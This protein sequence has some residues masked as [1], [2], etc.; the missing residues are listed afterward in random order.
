MIA[1][2]TPP[3]AI[4]TASL[5]SAPSTWDA[6]LTLLLRRYP[7]AEWG[8]F[9]RFGWRDTPDGLVLTLAALDQPT[10]GDLDPR[11]DIVAFQEPYTLR[12]VLDTEAGPLAFGVIHSHPE[13][14]RTWPSALD[15]DMDTY[16]SGYVAGFTPE[17]PYVSLIVARDED[18]SVRA[19]GRVFWRGQWRP[20][21]AF[22]VL[23]HHVAL[24]PPPVDHLIGPALDQ[25]FGGATAAADADLDLRRVAR[26]ASAFGAEA[27]ARL[28]RA[29]VAVIGA[30]GTGSPILEVLARAGVGRIITVDPDAFSASNLERVHGSLLTDVP[31]EGKEGAPKVVLAQRH[32]HAI[33]PHC[34][35]IA[36][37]G[38]LPQ[39]AVLDA[40]LH[41]DVAIGCTDQIHSR[42]ALSELAAR[43]LVPVLDVGV[44]LEGE[45]GLCSGLVVGLTRFLPEDPCA[46]CRGMVD[47]ARLTREL[48]SPGER[49]ARRAAAA[50]AVARGEDGGAYWHDDPQLNTVGFLT[51]TAGGMAAGYAIGWVTG[52]FVLPFSRTEMNLALP[53]FGVA[54]Q[55]ETEG[56]PE[57]TCTCRLMLGHADQGA[58]HTFL[59]APAHWVPVVR[60]RDLK[61]LPR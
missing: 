28:A 46:Y 40:V 51:T 25:V 59:T 31:P 41:A 14:Y 19:S 60:H 36:L 42:V 48:M 44:V 54:D 15:D 32:I 55:T 45:E 3:R 10:P 35:V 12:S 24:D 23:P 8:T 38:A 27:A 47:T 50:E 20:I 4:L 2:R 13:G 5:R 34:E 43:F 57:P 61:S 53:W 30:S 6:L 17:R 33:N 26:L 1:P 11:T 52:R 9:A 58:V 16:L 56:A 7:Y 39:D 29:T 21:T 18:G 37:E 49:E 22:R